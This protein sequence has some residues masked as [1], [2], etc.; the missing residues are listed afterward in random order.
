M[1][2]GSNSFSQMYCMYQK[3]IN[4]FFSVTAATKMGCS[5]KFTGKSGKIT[6]SDQ[7]L[8]IGYQDN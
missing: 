8:L 2:K 3:L 7:E 4:D 1:E 6:R 5:V